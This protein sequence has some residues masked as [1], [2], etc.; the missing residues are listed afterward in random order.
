[1]GILTRRSIYLKKTQKPG[2]LALGAVLIGIVAILIVYLVMIATGLIQISR[3]HITIATDSASKLYDGEAL[4][5]DGW[6]LVGGKLLEGHTVEATVTGSQTEVG[7]SDNHV[8]VYIYDSEGAEVTDKYLIEY[9]L[10]K[11]AVN[12]QRLEIVSGSAQKYYDGLPLTCPDWYIANG[13]LGAGHECSV[14]V[15]GI[16]TTVGTFPNTM[17]VRIIDTQSG[18]DVTSHYTLVATEGTLEI[19]G[20]R[21][22]ISGDFNISNGVVDMKNVMV[23]GELL[24]G[25]TLRCDPIDQNI[26]NLDINAVHAYVVDEK[27]NDVTEFYEIIYG[28]DMPSIDLPLDMITGQGGMGGGG[29]GGGNAMG[30]G[31][32]SDAPTYACFEVLTTKSGS[33]Y[34]RASSYGDF[35]GTNWVAA[36]ASDMSDITPFSLTVDA[37]KNGGVYKNETLKVKM[38]ADVFPYMLPYYA[39]EFA[40]NYINDCYA[41]WDYTVNEAYTVQFSYYEYLSSHNYSVSSAAI[42][43]KYRTYWVDTQYLNVNEDTR[44]ELLKLAEAAGIRAD[45]ADVIEA[46]R[47]YINSAA[48]YDLDCAEAPDGVDKV[49]YFLTQ[50]K[51]GVCR[52]FA[53]AATL[54]YRSLG[55]PARYVEGFAVDA[56]EDAWVTV[57]SD[58]AHAWVEVYIDGMGW[59]A[60][61]V[62]PP[63][64]GGTGS[65]NGSGTGTGNGGSGGG[66]VER[67][68]ALVIDTGSASKDYDG[69][70]LTQSSIDWS[71]F[72]KANAYWTKQKGSDIWVCSASGQKGHYFRESE[73]TVTGSQLY[74]GS[75]GNFVRLT[76]YDAEGNDVTSEYTVLVTGYLEV[77]PITLTV[78]SA[79][80]AGNADTGVW[81]EAYSVR[82]EGNRKL[83]DGHSISVQFDITE[84]TPFVYKGEEQNTFTVRILDGDGNDITS[85][86]YR[87]NKVY[88]TL[89]VK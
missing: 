48:T 82:F 59:V 13:A 23:S 89:T 87:I 11:L 66:A 27:G 22:I 63:S 83:L 2:Y 55:I 29:F 47:D 64:S 52:H 15:T 69:T 28:A 84:Q 54:M 77:K 46:V 74:A 85:L 60:V 5:A 50:S 81:C 72:E 86:Y 17:A 68:H 26:G 34:M 19:S 30:A 65:G 73:V 40:A 56:V 58:R 42:E 12:G 62:T 38:L 57:M 21:L 4:T 7:V 76:V 37:L 71:D 3:Q 32:G 25:H 61:E 33:L 75:S 49:I 35:D 45:S 9:Q 43:Q 24:P 36:S 14:T 70:V 6:E 18:E 53:T 80:A 10:G 39:N 44:A 78:V 67:K 16:A 41:E 88:G 51:S 8:T 79:S 31:P 20:I 1:M